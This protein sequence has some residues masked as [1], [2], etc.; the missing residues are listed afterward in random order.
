[1]IMTDCRS[2][3]ELGYW[4]MD[5]FYDPSSYYENNYYYMIYTH[6]LVTE[7]RTLHLIPHSASFRVFHV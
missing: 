1:M 3:V 5:F 2:H 4:I 7:E 6:S